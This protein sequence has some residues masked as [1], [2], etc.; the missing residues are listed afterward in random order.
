MGYEHD[1]KK[2][3]HARS[4]EGVLV[5][6]CKPDKGALG[7]PALCQCR[8]RSDDDIA[9]FQLLSA[10]LVLAIVHQDL[11]TVPTCYLLKHKIR[12]CTL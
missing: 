8:V 3:A 10:L 5:A 11:E 4:G 2:N 1:L 9:L 7:L 12:S 6:R